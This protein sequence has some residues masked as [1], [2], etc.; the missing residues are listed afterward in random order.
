MVWSLRA[1]E[2]GKEPRRDHEDKEGPEGSVEKK[3]AGKPLAGGFFGVVM[4]L[5]QD[6][7]WAV[8]HLDVPGH[9]SSKHPCPW[10]CAAW[11]QVD[12]KKVV[13]ARRRQKCGGTIGVLTLR[14]APPVGRT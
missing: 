11:T 5:K 3:R 14:G 8:N 12:K 10:C 13:Q 9:M 4:A 1:L 2:E 6:L 7:D